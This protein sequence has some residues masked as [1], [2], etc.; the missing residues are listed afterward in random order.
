MRDSISANQS[1]IVWIDDLSD[2]QHLMDLLRQATALRMRLPYGASLDRSEPLFYVEPQE[3]LPEKEP[4][5]A[6]LA[7]H[8]G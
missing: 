2:T 8:A 6:P 3:G 4:P 1:G 7:V 5:S